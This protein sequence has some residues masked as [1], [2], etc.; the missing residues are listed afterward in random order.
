MD[1]HNTATELADAALGGLKN[2]ADEL[3]NSI[4]QNDLSGAMESIK[5]INALKEQSLYKALGEMATKLHGALADLN[6]SLPGTSAEDFSNEGAAL[7]GGLNQIIQLTHESSSKTLDMVDAGLPAASAIADESKEC[8]ALVAQALASAQSGSEIAN[9]LTRVSQHLES[10]ESRATLLADN[11]RTIL[12]SQ[13]YQ[14]LTSQALKK[15]ITIIQKIESNLSSLISYANLVQQAIN[16]S[17][18]PEQ[19]ADPAKRDEL[20]SSL[21]GLSEESDILDQG[22][23]DELLSSL[24]F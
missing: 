13:N 18:N 16:L 21:G 7:A 9:V 23:V 19:A 5:K 1:T 4:H 17:E 22:D 14:D 6:E 15:I 8:K 2:Q 20:A 24:G 12:M 10:S 11:L 3:L